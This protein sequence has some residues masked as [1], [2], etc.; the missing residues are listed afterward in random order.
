MHF[1]TYLFYSFFLYTLHVS[2]D[3]FVHRQECVSY[4]ICS[5]VHTMQKVPNCSPEQLD[6]FCIL[7][8]CLCNGFYNSTFK[9]LDICLEKKI[10]ILNVISS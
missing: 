10:N 9:A 4:C 2:N 5:F 6:T 7:L 8:V 1:C 3:Y